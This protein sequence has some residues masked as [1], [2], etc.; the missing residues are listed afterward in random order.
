MTIVVGWLDSIKESFTV[1]YGMGTSVRPFEHRTEEITVVSDSML[2]FS[3]TQGERIATHE[4]FPKI[5]S[6]NASFQIPHCSVGRISHFTPYNCGDFG[7]TFAGSPVLAQTILSKIRKLFTDELVV[8]YDL[9]IVHIKHQRAPI[10]HEHVFNEFMFRD[11]KIL[12]LENIALLLHSIIAETTNEYVIKNYGINYM[13]IG[14]VT[15][16][17]GLIG[18]C[19]VEKKPQIFEFL[20]LH[21][22]SEGIIKIEK[23][24]LVDSP[25]FIHGSATK[26]I[27]THIMQLFQDAVSNNK[28]ANELK[29]MLIEN[30]SSQR[31]E[32]YGIGGEIQFGY[33][34]T[35][36]REFILE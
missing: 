11:Y 16:Q 5:H 22:S 20:P 17:I 31:W 36:E 3:N 29:K 28:R 9:D 13:E 4:S 26:E 23:K 2:S 24:E 10:R 33:V 34:N 12:S 18:Y 30:I 19:N 7:I 25:I 1:D 35:M 6:I 15:C 21:D 8:S 14:Q 27:K 32:Q